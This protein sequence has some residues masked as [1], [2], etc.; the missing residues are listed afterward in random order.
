MKTHERVVMAV[1]VQTQERE[2]TAGVG[3]NGRVVS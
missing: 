2:V 3:Q 1:V